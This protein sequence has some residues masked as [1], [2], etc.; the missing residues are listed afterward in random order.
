MDDGDPAKLQCAA[1]NEKVDL[2]LPSSCSISSFATNSTSSSHLR[3]ASLDSLFPQRPSFPPSSS[4]SPLHPKLTSSRANLSVSVDR[5]PSTDTTS[6]FPLIIAYTWQPW[7]PAQAG[8][9]TTHSRSSSLSSW[10]SRV[11]AKPHSSRGSCTTPSTTCT[12]RPLAS[13]SFPRQDSPRHQGVWR[14]RY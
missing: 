1:Q 12:K 4:F 10:A 7:R 14:G 13:T 3:K 6:S 11:S 5:V 9:T 8:L 2:L